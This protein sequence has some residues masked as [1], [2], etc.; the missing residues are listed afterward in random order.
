[1]R[2]YGRTTVIRNPYDIRPA[3]TLFDDR[4]GADHDLGG[5]A[6]PAEEDG[7]RGRERRRDYQAA[8]SGAATRLS[9]CRLEPD[10]GGGRVFAAGRTLSLFGFESIF[11]TI[12]YIIGIL[13][14]CS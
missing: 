9:G 1:M 13:A 6:G 14:L 12:A 2:V 4:R 11:D 7:L 8:D 5:D 3:I 10:T